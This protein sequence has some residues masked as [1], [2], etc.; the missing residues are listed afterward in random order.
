MTV[1]SG[2]DYFDLADYL[3]VLR[4]R[5]L[6]IVVFIVVGIGLAAAYYVVAPRVYGSTVL[7]QVNALPTNANAV[8]GRTGGPVNMDNEAQILESATVG[9]IAK[10]DLGSALTVVALLHQ[11]K[12]TVPPNTTFLQVSCDAASPA[13]AQRCANA[14][15]RA[16]LYN[17]RQSELGLLTSSISQ[18]N[19]QAT[20]LETSIEALKVKLKDTI[21]AGSTEHG[22]AELQLTARTTRLDTIQAKISAVTPLE[23]SLTAKNDY[24]GQV[25]TPATKIR[26]PVSPEKKLLLPSGLAGGAVLG[27][28][29]AFF[30]DW[31]RP[32]ITEVRDIQRRVDLPIIVSPADMKTGAQS[33]FAPPRSRTGQAFTELAQHIGTELGDGHHVLVVTGTSTGS[34]GPVSANLAGALA[35][36][37]GDTVLICA[38]PTGTAVPRLLGTND[39]R[40]F[41]ELLAGTASLADVTRR[42]ADLPLLQVITPGLDA[43]GAVYDM[44]HDKVQRLM[45][46]LRREVRYVVIDLPPASSDA[47]TFSLAEFSDGAIIVVRAGLDRPADLTDCVARLH[48]MRTSLL[49]GVLLPANA[50]ERRG[51]GRRDDYAADEPPARYQAPRPVPLAEPAAPVPPPS[52]QAQS[53]TTRPGS[54]PVPHPPIR[55]SGDEGSNASQPVLRPV[56]VRRPASPTGSA[57]L[58]TVSRH[59]ASSSDLGSASEPKE[60]ASLSSAWKPRSVSETWPLPRT[61]VTEEGEA[62]DNADP[63]LGD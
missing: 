36:S 28:L 9:V 41:A 62:P 21:P 20:A 60:S 7:I 37:R 53:P 13:L 30:W 55:P 43:A 59:A 5:W 26:K 31:R 29:F 16:Y 2:S 14:F 58:P 40:G 23:A 18:L 15:G 63:L 35:R 4:R 11:I 10:H 47:D 57:D 32:R 54:P 61:A 42:T 33:S 56:P 44:Q 22:I 12:V 1:P 17:R 8:G 38:D 51:Q 34:A 39:G 50:K 24:V 46:E 52:V 6:M 49:A 25:V 48:G 27:L 45:R 3:G 19:V